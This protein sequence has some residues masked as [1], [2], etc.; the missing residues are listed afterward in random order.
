M[1]DNNRKRSTMLSSLVG[2]NAIV[3]G[4]GTGKTLSLN[5][6]FFL[7]LR[8]ATSCQDDFLLLFDIVSCTLIDTIA[9]SDSP[10]TSTPV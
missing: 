4:G 2:K 7:R 9:V 6:Q 10:C 8:C 1:I 3:T 5:Q